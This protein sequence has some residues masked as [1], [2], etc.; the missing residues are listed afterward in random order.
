VIP[1]VS[2]E[3]RHFD[4]VKV[5]EELPETRD[6]ITY[7]RVIMNPAAT[8]D[9]FPGH[10]DPEYARAQGQP[11]IFVNTM[12]IMGFVDR[13]VSAWG[14]PRTFLVKRKVALS[15]PVYAG[16]AMVGTGVVVATREEERDGHRRGLV[17]LECAVDNQHGARCATAG[18]TVTLPLRTA[19]AMERPWWP[20]EG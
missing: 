16:D 5:G 13:L 10:H 11:T 3:Q 20:R 14:G 17:E 18:L 1:G 7:R 4:D 6:E 19:D 12:H 2:Y 9:F 8:L 15:F